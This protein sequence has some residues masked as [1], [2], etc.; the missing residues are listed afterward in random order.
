VNKIV[1]KIKLTMDPA[2]RFKKT[3]FINFRSVILKAK[4]SR[5]TNTNRAMI[6]ILVDKKRQLTLMVRTSIENPRN[7]SPNIERC[8]K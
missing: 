7:I 3:D 5:L 6:E 8:Q 2:L 4:S 1:P